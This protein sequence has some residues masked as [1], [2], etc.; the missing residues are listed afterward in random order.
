MYKRQIRD[1]VQKAEVHL[2]DLEKYQ[3]EY[4][5]VDGVHPNKEGMKMLAGL[6]MKE[7]AL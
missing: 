5:T 1:C 7:L 4:E 2:A 6:W 3:E